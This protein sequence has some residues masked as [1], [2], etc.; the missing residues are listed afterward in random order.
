M[1][2]QIP[3]KLLMAVGI[4]EI[5]QLAAADTS[6]KSKLWYAAIIGGMCVFYKLAQLFGKKNE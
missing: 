5:A 6:S 3:K 1:D 4:A 2:N